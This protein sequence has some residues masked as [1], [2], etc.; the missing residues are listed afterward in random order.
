MLHS[1]TFRSIIIILVV[2][3][4]TSTAYALAAGNTFSDV[5]NQAGDGADTIS[6]YDVSNVAYTLDTNNP[7]N[8]T[9]VTFTL[10]AFATTVKVSLKGEALQSCSLVSGN[11]WSCTISGVTATE[12]NSLRVSAAQ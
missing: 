10:D 7:A 2:L 11:D 12:A 1:R 6:G 8:V 5:T 4:F 3:V 9:K